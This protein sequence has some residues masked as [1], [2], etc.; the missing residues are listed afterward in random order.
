MNYKFW[1]EVLL[2]WSELTHIANPKDCEIIKDMNI[3]FNSRILINKKCVFYKS[4]YNVGIQKIGD[5][6]CGNNLFLN[7]QEVYQKFN[8]L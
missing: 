3:W 5:L 1:V 6:L 2:Y 8:V 7:H 4:W